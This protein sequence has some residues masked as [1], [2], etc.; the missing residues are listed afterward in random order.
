MHGVRISRSF[1]NA[2]CC[3]V[4]QCVAVYSSVQ[5]RVAVCVPGGGGGGS[6][7]CVAGV[8]ARVANPS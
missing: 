6:G 3:L 4:L 7:V 2:V 1:T 8:K 5:Q